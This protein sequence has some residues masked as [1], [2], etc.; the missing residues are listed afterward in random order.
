MPR[1]EPLYTSANGI[2]RL[3]ML[4]RNRN[5]TAQN[6]SEWISIEENSWEFTLVN[7]IINL[8]MCLGITDG[9]FSLHLP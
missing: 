1:G 9:F 3:L 7:T 4:V 8:V 2:N 5:R 6:Q